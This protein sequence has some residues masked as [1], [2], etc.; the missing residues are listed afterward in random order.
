MEGERPALPSARAER[1]LR[2]RKIPPAGCGATA[3][4]ATWRATEWTRDG[5]LLGSGGLLEPEQRLF[6]DTPW[7]YNRIACIP[8]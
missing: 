3:P 8:S 5:Q 1:G 4:I 7:Q 2:A 6:N